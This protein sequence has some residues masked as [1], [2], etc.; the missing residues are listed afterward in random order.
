LRGG[1][2]GSKKILEKRQCLDLQRKRSF[3]GSEGPA[4]NCKKSLPA[5]QRREDAG[6]M[7]GEHT[8][9]GN[10]E[11]PGVKKYAFIGIREKGTSI[12]A[13]RRRTHAKRGTTGKKAL[14]NRIE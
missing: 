2:R 13:K 7:K 5:S 10:R 11:N 12:N 4:I 8:I 9:L 14:G 1:S 3:K 6:G